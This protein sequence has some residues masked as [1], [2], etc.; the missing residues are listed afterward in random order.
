MAASRSFLGAYY[1]RLAYYYSPS[2]RRLLLLR[3][4]H[5]S[6]V[7]TRANSNKP[8]NSL[9]TNSTACPARQRVMIRS[10]GHQVAECVRDPFDLVRGVVMRN[11]D[12]DDTA[13]GYAE[14]LGQI[15]CVEVPAANEDALFP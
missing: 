2:A 7:C 6:E 10:L 13:L 4:A 12:A 5:H 9:N 14:C 8:S 1:L 15:E 3:S 11:S